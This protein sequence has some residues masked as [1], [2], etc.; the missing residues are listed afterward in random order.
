[1][2]VRGGRPLRG[3][4]RVHGAKNAALP[5]MAACLLVEEPVT[6]HRVPRLRDV[7]TTTG[8]LRALGMRVEWVGPHSM[9]LHRQSSD[10]VV[11]PFDLVRRMRASVCALGPLLATRRA[12]VM[13]LPGGCVIGERPI[14]L[15][16]KGLAALGAEFTLRGA[17]LEARSGRLRGASVNMRG[18]HGSTC[19]GTANV[20]MAAATA[21]GVS[22]IEGAAREPE[23]QDLARF[24]NACG[25]RI[26]GIGT[27]RLVV[28]GVPRLHGADYTIIPD[29]I[30]AGTFLAAVGAAGGRI[31]VEGACPEHMAATLTALRH[32]GLGIE[33]DADRL[34]AEPA[35]PLTAAGLVT[36]PFPALPTDMQPQLI[37]LLCL[38]G[39]E[40]TVE[41]R[42][43]PQRFTHVGELIRMGARILREGPKAVIQGVPALR[44]AEVR[45]TDLRAGAALVLAGLAAEGTTTIAGVEQIERGYQGLD[46]RL[47]RLGADVGRAPGEPGDQPAR[48]PA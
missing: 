22:V 6:L 19:L 10:L 23:V 46:E 24:L 32:L 39:G 2:V 44:G 38:A 48:R 20:M 13:P 29:R 43:Y 9:T 35:R 33:R 40:S 26:A 15:H 25:A 34:T 12:A 16:L 11:A 47:A 36:G 21:E 31:T 27:D 1:M 28:E 42:V 4:V 5:I 41:E 8:L 17:R 14:D 7:Q 37:V 3:T 30:E 45:A 18:P